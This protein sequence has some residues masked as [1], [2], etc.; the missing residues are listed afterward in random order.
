MSE[1]VDRRLPGPSADHDD[2]EF[3]IVQ[4]EQRLNR[5]LDAGRRSTGTTMLTGIVK[6]DTDSAS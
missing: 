6:R 5:R 1:R 4:I 3:R 2:F